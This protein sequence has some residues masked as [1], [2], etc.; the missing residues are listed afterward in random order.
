MRCSLSQDAWAQIP[1][2]CRVHMPVSSPTS[3]AFPKTHQWVGF[4][5]DPLR[6]FRAVGVR[7]RRHSLR[8]GLLVCSP[9][10]S[11]LPLRP[12]RRRAAVTSTP[13]KTRTV[14]GTCIGYA[15]RPNQA[16]DGRGLSPPNFNLVGR[17]RVCLPLNTSAS[18]DALP[19][20]VS[21]VRLQA[22]APYQPCPARN[23]SAV[24]LRF[25]YPRSSHSLTWPS[26]PVHPPAYSLAFSASPPRSTSAT[27][28]T[29]GS[30]APKGLC[31]P[32]PPCYYARSASL[33]RSPDFP[34]TWSYRGSSPDNLVWALSRLSLLWLPVCLRLPSCT[35]AGRPLA[36]LRP[37]TSAR[38]SAI[39][40]SRV[41]GI[42]IPTVSSERPLGLLVDGSDDAISSLPLRPPKLFAPWTDRPRCTRIGPPGLLH[43]SLLPTGS[44]PPGVGYH[45]GAELGNLRRRVLPRKTGNVTG[46]T[47]TGS[48]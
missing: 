11:L 19:D 34:G 21:P 30:F 9:P 44:P 23:T 15:S 27:T 35:H 7:D 43:P 39:A 45:Y 18:P 3:S 26:S 12:Q 2:G 5:L 33:D 13:S 42:S 10:R 32:F 46:C 14:T 37:I 38:A 28:S 22:E 48:R 36:C 20:G 17:S 29:H 6:D 25:A 40:Q 47:G 31:C 4:P 16:I 8:S 1:A 24:K 41:L